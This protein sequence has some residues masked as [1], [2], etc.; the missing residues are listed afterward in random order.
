MSDRSFCVRPTACRSWIATSPGCAARY[1]ASGGFAL[2]MGRCA[3]A[4]GQLAAIQAVQAVASGQV[5][6]CIAVGALMDLSHW[7]CQGLRSLGAM[8]SDEASRTSRNSHVGRFD[9]R[10]DGF[11]F[12]ESCGVVVVERAGAAPRVWRESCA[13]VAGW[14]VRMDANRNPNPS[15][16]GEV[17]VIRQASAKGRV[18][19]AV[20][21]LCQSA[22]HRIEIR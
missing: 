10:T 19:C 21:R 15:F 5:D 6:V 14:G 20:H 13:R 7:E 1:S 8:G 3:S 11:I 4:S 16:E 2:H 18:R 9:R 17:G 22:W 12:G